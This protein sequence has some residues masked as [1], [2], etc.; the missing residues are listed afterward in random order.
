MDF[1]PLQIVAYSQCNWTFKTGAFPSISPSK[2]GSSGTNTITL[3]GSFFITAYLILT[4]IVSLIALMTS[5]PA[6]L[7]IK[8]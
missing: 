1:S 3:N 6:V 4:T 7:L 5:F 8:N 2:P